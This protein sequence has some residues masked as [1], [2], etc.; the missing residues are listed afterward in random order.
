MGFGHS[1]SMLKKSKAANGASNTVDLHLDVLFVHRYICSVARSYP[2]KSFSGHS[3]NIADD[4]FEF[5]FICK[6][7]DNF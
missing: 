3:A 1:F 2:F 5:S 4:I 6:V 7:N